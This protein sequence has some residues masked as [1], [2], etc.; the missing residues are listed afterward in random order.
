MKSELLTFIGFDRKTWSI[1]L[2]NSEVLDILEK[3]RNLMKKPR[4]WIL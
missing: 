4:T 3:S 2:I 1:N